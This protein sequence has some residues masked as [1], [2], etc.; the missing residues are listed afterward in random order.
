MWER[1]LRRAGWRLAHTQG[2]NPR[3]RISFAAALPVGV[4]GEAELVEMYL[5]DPRPPER[6]LRELA[7]RM[8]PGAEVRRVEEI[9]VE[10]P[11][12][13]QRLVAAEYLAACPSENGPGQLHAE[14]LR[15]LAAESLPRV[16][17]KEARTVR[18]DL[19]PLV[20]G[21]AVEDGLPGRLLVR[22]ELRADAQGAGRPDEVLRELG[23]EPAD[24]EVTRTRLILGE[25][26]E[27]E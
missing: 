4:A 17:A 20:R 26:K 9:P 22:M 5:E 16:R 8:P 11:G 1:V 24:C 27:G 14:V 15:V 13:Q 12:L 7:E 23:L 6:A 25:G 19:R 2:F 3:P 18:Y 21:L 10:A